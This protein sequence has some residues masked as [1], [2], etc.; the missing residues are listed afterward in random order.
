[1][2]SSPA[3]RLQGISAL[4]TG[5]WVPAEPS[6]SRGRALGRLHGRSPSVGRGRLLSFPRRSLHPLGVNCF[7]VRPQEGSPWSS[8]PGRTAGKPRALLPDRRV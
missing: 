4:L 2:L 8:E 5:S 6:W 3:L 1:M 7:L